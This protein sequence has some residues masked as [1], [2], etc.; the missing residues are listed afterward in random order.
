MRRTQRHE[1]Q[2]SISDKTSTYWREFALNE[3]VEWSK[4]L[5]RGN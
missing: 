1:K 3:G 5:S 4:D 2:Y